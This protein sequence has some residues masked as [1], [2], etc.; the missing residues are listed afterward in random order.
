[1]Y[2][3]FI[4]PLQSPFTLPSSPLHSPEFLRTAPVSCMKLPDIDWARERERFLLA[5]GGVDTHI[6]SSR[7]IL[8]P[9]S[10]VLSCFGRFFFQIISSGLLIFITTCQRKMVNKARSSQQELEQRSEQGEQQSWQLC[11]SALSTV[12]KSIPQQ[13]RC[14]LWSFWSRQVI[15][16]NLFA[17]SQYL[18]VGAVKICNP[19]LLLPCCFSCQ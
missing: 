1:M 18:P 4:A 8:Y 11:F 5:F 2:K 6:V 7:V 9:C 17:Q 16:R 12:G 14:H 15:Y 10:F 13:P 3:L 19:S